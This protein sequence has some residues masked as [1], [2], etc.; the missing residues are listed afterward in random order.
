MKN[1]ILLITFFIACQAIAVQA[2]N[3]VE[4]YFYLQ[5]KAVTLVSVIH[6][7]NSKNWCV[8]GRYNYEEQNSFSLYTG[9]TFSKTKA[10]FSHSLTPILGG[11]MGRFKGGSMGL[12]ATLEYK[13]FAFSS[14]SQYTVSFK[15]E[16]A[17]PDFFFS[18]SELNYEFLPW[19]YFGCSVQHTFYTQEKNHLLEPGAVLGFTSG[20]WTFPI[21]G[22]SL[23][24]ENRYFVLGISVQFAK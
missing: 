4:Q 1:R 10:E 22:F 8:E 6:A 23:L 14:Q 16:E 12:N 5:K 7:Q 11:V 2:Q 18:W 15:K 24:K 13:R 17:H 21:Y 20:K 19:L 3:G 9:K